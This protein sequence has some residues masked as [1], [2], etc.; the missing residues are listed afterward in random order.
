MMTAHEILIAARARIAQPERWTKKAF[1]RNA[2][3]QE[4]FPISA[5]AVC[6]CMMGAMRSV[7]YTT[8]SDGYFVIHS[9]DPAETAIENAHNGLS[10]PELN[11]NDKTTHADVLAMFDRAI[12]ATAEGAQ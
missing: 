7:A 1:A 8:T 5:S 6:W 4:V 10:C 9:V 11:D 12:A 3:G 2:L